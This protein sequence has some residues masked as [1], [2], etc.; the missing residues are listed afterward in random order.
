MVC[1]QCFYSPNATNSGTVPVDYQWDVLRTPPI[2]PKEPRCT[3]NKL[4]EMTELSCGNECFLDTSEEDMVCV[5]V[6][7]AC[8]LEYLL[9]LGGH[10]R[11][12]AE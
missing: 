6:E 2:E 9:F 10:G 12:A 8:I 7:A 4:R 1:T 11:R 3:S 5:H